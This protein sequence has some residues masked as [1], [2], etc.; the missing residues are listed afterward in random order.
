MYKRYHHSNPIQKQ[1]VYIDETYLVKRDFVITPE[2]FNNFSSK[3]Y[4]DY[5]YM[6]YKEKALIFFEG[7]KNLKW[8]EWRYLQNEDFIKNSQHLS[9]DKPNEINITD[10][11]K[12]EDFDHNIGCQSIS[13]K[14]A[15]VN[16]CLSRDNYNTG[17]ISDN[18]VIKTSNLVNECTKHDSIIKHEEN[19][20]NN[21]FENDTTRNNEEKINSKINIQKNH[22]FS[23]QNSQHFEVKREKYLY[24]LKKFLDKN[25]KIINDIKLNTK[26]IK[27]DL[28]DNIKRHLIVK[29]RDQNTELNLIEDFCMKC[30]DILETNFCIRKNGNRSKM[31]MN[32]DVDDF[33]LFAIITVKPDSNLKE[34]AEL[35]RVLDCQ[36]NC[37]LITTQKMFVNES[38]LDP[39]ESDVERCKKILQ[40]FCDKYK[41]A[42]DITGK[43]LAFIILLL[44]YVFCYCYLCAYH[45]DSHAELVIECG[46]YHIFNQ[47][48]NL[49]ETKE[50]QRNIEDYQDVKNAFDVTVDDKTKTPKAFSNYDYSSR[51]TSSKLASTIDQKNDWS[52][53]ESIKDLQHF[54]HTTDVQRLIEEK[55]LTRKIFNR[56]NEIIT[57]KKNLDFLKTSNITNDIF[58]KYV[59]EQENFFSCCVPQCDKQFDT[60]ENVFNH[61][62]TKHKDYVSKL[63][64]ENDIFYKFIDNIDLW[65]FYHTEK[66]GMKNIPSFLRNL[67]DE[68]KERSNVIYD[69]KSF[70]SGN[71]LN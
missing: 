64:F 15:I 8:F 12:I 6:F 30:P 27:F 13:P 14:T 53:P 56:K 45:Y 1:S 4:S 21:N 2:E 26:N 24:N 52:N 47:D 41:I 54:H 70:Y 5:Q 28:F 42:I 25:Q 18:T 35:L 60:K 67:N 3:S 11:K 68:K 40:L 29:W 33:Q 44:R 9:K 58:K 50:S 20:L 46:D 38:I 10:N 71:L 66:L 22:I 69:F 43:S 55:T 23:M 49:H 57:L 19:S 62:N 16:T 7:Y 39:E 59:S 61:L 37:D 32:Y 48:K 63:E 17:D 65:F 51:L 31:Q 34:T 36:F